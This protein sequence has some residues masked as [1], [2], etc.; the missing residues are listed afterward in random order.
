M[1]TFTPVDHDPFADES[2]SA[3]RFTPVEHDPFASEKPT[4]L[5]KAVEPITSLP[6]T[7]QGMVEESVGQ[8]GRGVGQIATGQPW[9]VA[10][11]V[12][13]VALGGLGYVTSPINAPLHTIVGKPLEENFGIPHEYSE[14]GA[15]L[16]LPGSG[17]TRAIRGAEPLVVPPRPVTSGIT[18]SKGEEAGSTAMRQAEQNFIRTGEPHAQAFQAQREQQIAAEN[19]RI[20]ASFNPSGQQ[21]A[22]TPA[23]AG[24]LAQE[25][26]Q[27]AAAARKAEVDT[28][29]AT[30]RRTPG[31]IHASALESMPNQIKQDLSLRDEPVIIDDRTTPFANKA[32]DDL[33][34]RFGQTRMQNKADPFAGP[35]GFRSFDRNPNVTLSTIDQMRKRLVTFKNDAYA[36]GNKADGRAAK[37]VLSAFDDRIDEAV[38]SNLFTG[39]PDAVKAWNNARAAHADYKTEFFAGK[40][41]PAGRVVEK[42]LGKYTNNPTSPQDV[43]RYFTGGQGVT[44]SSLNINVANRMKTILG[45]QSPE[46]AAIKQ[47]V[48][49]NLVETPEGVANYGTDKLATRLGK[50]V[51]SDLGKALYSPDEQRT[52][53]A[54]SNLMRKITMPPGSYNPSAPGINKAIGVVSSNLGRMLGAVIG[55]HIIPI[56]VVGEIAGAGTA[57]GVGHVAGRM[58]MANMAK[59]LPLVSDQIKVWQKAANKATRQSNADWSAVA[60]LPQ[61]QQLSNSLSRLGI[62]FQSMLPAEGSPQDNRQ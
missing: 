58:Q 13:N 53:Q 40:N 44:S 57:A 24:Q 56:P 29:Y 11:G 2:S 7:Y 25:A 18:L 60:K 49:R 9:E 47:G 1:P 51:N 52:L 10:K 33:Q 19:E 3:P 30:A 41:D 23:E 61:T 35:S 55:R 42:I 37:A 50:F 38:N 4:A 8:M 22:E 31:E 39:S 45:E 14:L 27:R 36:S 17:V 34:S 5:E 26:A 32:I 48:F 16:L 59:Q 12:G 43:A 6:S 15:S 46:W 28:A 62:D 54:Y 20:A 21:I